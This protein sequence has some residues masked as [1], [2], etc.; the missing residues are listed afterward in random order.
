VIALFGVGALAATVFL[1]Y[2]LEIL[3]FRRLRDRQLRRAATMVGGAPPSED[4]IAEEI[5]REIETG[6]FDAIDPD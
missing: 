6:E 3:K 1:V 4:Q 5:E 2:T